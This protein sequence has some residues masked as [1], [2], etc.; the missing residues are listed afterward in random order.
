MHCTGAFLNQL[1][2]ISVGVNTGL[3]VC[4]VNSLPLRFPPEAFPKYLT[5]FAERWPYH[6]QNFYKTGVRYKIY[7]NHI[8]EEQQPHP[9]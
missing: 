1:F 7:Q 5:T 8:R 4:L 3:V 9:P 2:L 6:H